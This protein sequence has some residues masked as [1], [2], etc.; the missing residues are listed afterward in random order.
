MTKTHEQKMAE[1]ATG[2]YQTGDLV[3]FD[4]D[5]KKLTKEQ[6]IELLNSNDDV[7]VPSAGAGSYREVFS[8]LGFQEVE[9]V[10]SQASAGDWTFGIKNDNGW[11]VGQQENNYP[12]TG[13]RYVIS[14]MIDCCQTFEELVE[15]VET[16]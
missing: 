9:V 11:V 3:F 15:K 5:G 4:N 1:E 16:Y 7:I 13:F 6:A 8:S 2:L 14:P 10:Y 12:A